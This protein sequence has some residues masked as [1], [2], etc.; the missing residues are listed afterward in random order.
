MPRIHI[1]KNCSGKLASVC[2][3]TNAADAT[4]NPIRK[5]RI[6]MTPKAPNAAVEMNHDNFDRA[7]SESDDGMLKKASHNAINEMTYAENAEVKNP[8]RCRIASKSHVPA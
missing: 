7:S 1:T 8:K 4:E 3:T 6:K 5:P 2:K